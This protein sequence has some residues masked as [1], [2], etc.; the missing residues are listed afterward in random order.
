MNSLVSITKHR[1]NCATK[2]AFA[3]KAEARAFSKEQ[4]RKRHGK[5]QHAYECPICGQWHL[6]SLPLSVATS[7]QQRIINTQRYL[8]L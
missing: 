5:K 2:R 3:T 6:S 7:V 4:V 1:D 8:G